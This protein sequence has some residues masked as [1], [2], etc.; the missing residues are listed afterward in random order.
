MNIPNY[1]DDGPIAEPAYPLMQWITTCEP[2]SK[3]ERFAMAA[4]QGLCANPDHTCTKYESLA[5]TARKQADRLI[6]ELEEN[7]TP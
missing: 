2:L 1:D 6:R 7:P 4:M 3:R 5:G